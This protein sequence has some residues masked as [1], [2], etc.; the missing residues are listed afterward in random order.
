MHVKHATV[1]DLFEKT[2]ERY[3]GVDSE[4][5]MST[6]EKED[7]TPAAGS[8][9]FGTGKP[10]KAAVVKTAEPGSFMDK[11]AG[12]ASGR[13]FAEGDGRDD[14]MFC[15]AANMMMGGGTGDAS[16]TGPGAAAMPTGMGHGKPKPKMP[17]Y[18]H[19]A[20]GTGVVEA[21][22]GHGACTC[23]GKG[24]CAGCKTKAAGASKTAEPN[25]QVD[26]ADRTGR[27]WTSGPIAGARNALFG[28]GKSRV[29][30]TNDTGS[31]DS[32]TAATGAGHGAGV[33]KMA[34][35]GT[36]FRKHAAMPTLEDLKGVG[37]SALEGAKEIPGKARELGLKAKEHG[38]EIL[39]SA[40]TGAREGLDYLKAN[41]T[42]AMIATGGAGLLAAKGLVG[43]G[44]AAIGRRAAKRAPSLLRRIGMRLARV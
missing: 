2:A 7:I 35:Y 23:S 40:G 27:D 1:Q 38:K 39:E 36:P 21:M 9:M 30:G 25:T 43:A 42:A 31:Y 44:R 13:F 4:G 29:H 15:K 41:P 33:K 26:G 14:G 12:A 34:A 16:S 3:E 8:A 24:T 10:K 11:I 22:H 37:A 28:H 6:N 18:G 32:G 17:E 5:K 20:P 19:K